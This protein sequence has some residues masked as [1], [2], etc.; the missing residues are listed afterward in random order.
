[1]K[2]GDNKPPLNGGPL[3]GNLYINPQAG[4]VRLIPPSPTKLEGVGTQEHYTAHAIEPIDYIM[5]NGMDFLEGNVIKYVTRYKLKNGVEDLKK[6]QQYLTW[7]IEREQ[8]KSGLSYYTNGEE[9]YRIPASA[10]PHTPVGVG[11]PDNPD[12]DEDDAS[13]RPG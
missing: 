7:L 2:H 10:T 4:H 12:Y 8:D 11:T 5:E 3:K 6:A 1:M 13:H 9:K